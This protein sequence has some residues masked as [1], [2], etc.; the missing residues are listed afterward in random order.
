VQS[1]FLMRNCNLLAR[2]SKLIANRAIMLKFKADG[3]G[4]SQRIDLASARIILTR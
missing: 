1:N 3:H 4:G 2:H